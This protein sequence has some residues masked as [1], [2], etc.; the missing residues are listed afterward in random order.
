MARGQNIG[1]KS[2]LRRKLRR[3]WNGAEKAPKSYTNCVATEL[4]GTTGTRVN[5]N[6][7]TMT[8]GQFIVFRDLQGV[9]TTDTLKRHKNTRL[10]S[11]NENRR[12]CDYFIAQRGNLICDCAA[13]RRAIGTRKGEQLT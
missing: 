13:A 3:D 4:N 11:Q 7:P 9:T 10:L 12:V 6:H 8:T 1:D 5:I 2:T